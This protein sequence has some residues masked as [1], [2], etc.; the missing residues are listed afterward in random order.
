[1]IAAA[2]PWSAR[3]LIVDQPIRFTVPECVF[4]QIAQVDEVISV[5]F[6][7]SNDG[8]E[9]LLGELNAFHAEHKANYSTSVQCWFRDFETPVNSLSGTVFDGHTI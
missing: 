2:G 5:C 4:Q 6:E 3:S 9:L 8:W 1:M 7:E